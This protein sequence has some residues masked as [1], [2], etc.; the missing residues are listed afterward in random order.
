MA[1]KPDRYIM[2]DLID[3]M[4][5][6]VSERGGVVTEIGAG[7]GAALDSASA[8]VKYS[9]NPSGFCPLGVLLQD[10]VNKDLTQTH[11]NFYKDEVQKGTKV[12]LMT[13]G[14]VVTNMFY[15]RNHTK[16]E[17]LYCGLSGLFDNVAPTDQSGIS[18]SVIGRLL[19]TLDEDG[20]GKVYV[21]LPAM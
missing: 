18:T 1:L 7:S 9:T 4:C 19:S 8:E 10:V 3:F 2:R 13:E 16:G 12:A 20:Y 6:T 14:W 21:K 11:L 17:K 5:D 15:T